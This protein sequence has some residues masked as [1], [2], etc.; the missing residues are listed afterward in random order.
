M[1]SAHAAVSSAT[2]RGVARRDWRCVCEHLNHSYAGSLAKIESISAASG[3]ELVVAREHMLGIRHDATHDVVEL[4][5]GDSD[6]F[7]HGPREIYI[8][9]LELGGVCLQIVDHS[10]VRQVVTL[11]PALLAAH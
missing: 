10:G 4:S 5:F 6:H 1:I 11:D 8:D 9:D 3:C 2:L 7:I